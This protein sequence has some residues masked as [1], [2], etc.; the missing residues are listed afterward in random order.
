MGILSKLF[1]R[2]PE[3]AA[4]APAPVPQPQEE[5][6]P[7]K[8]ADP[9]KKTYRVA[10][11]SFRTDAVLSLATEN[12][13]YK[14]TKTQLIRANVPT[15]YQYLFNVRTTELVPEPDNP[16]DPHAIKV[17]MDGAH[18]GYIKAGNCTHILNLMRDDK[19]E[20]ITGKLYGGP[21]KQ[22]ECIGEPEMPET[23]S[24]LPSSDYELIH[25]KE[26]IFSARVTIIKK[27]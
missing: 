8:P 17:I 20:S 11:I 2:K 23:L 4:P 12:P 16:A 15:A 21:S 22:L 5:V 10:G 1:G 18:I 7:R 6:K 25:D 26:M 13:D 14:L 27:A 9:L 24:S 19:I 3:A